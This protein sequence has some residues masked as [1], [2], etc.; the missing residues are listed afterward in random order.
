M[1]HR[2]AGGSPRKLRLLGI[3]LVPAVGVVAALFG[4]ATSTSQAARAD[5]T[6]SLSA[7][8]TAKFTEPAAFDVS[9]PLRVLAKTRTAATSATMP[10]ERPFITSKDRGH[11]GDGAVQ[12]EL[13]SPMI[14]AP[15]AN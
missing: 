7:P 5:E 6:G 3:A 10:P 13:P 2:S 1:M 8:L 12:G 9:S 11:S 15:I 14:P 4:G